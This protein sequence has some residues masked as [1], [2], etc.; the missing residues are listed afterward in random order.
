MTRLFHQTQ[1]LADISA[2]AIQDLVDRFLL[3]KG[4]N[5]S[6]SVDPRVDCFISNKLAQGPFGCERR[7]VEQFDQARHGDPRVIPSDDSE[8]LYTLV[9]HADALKW[10][11]TDVFDDPLMQLIPSGIARTRMLILALLRSTPSLLPDLRPWCKYCRL[12]QCRSV[13]GLDAR[14]SH[15]LFGHKVLE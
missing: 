9:R 3:L 6:R 15:Q 5:A 12:P 14:P 7:Q 10:G 11:K 2:P 13:Y 1:H 4:D 8:I